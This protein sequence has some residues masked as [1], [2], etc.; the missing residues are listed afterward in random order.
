MSF[1]L[2]EPRFPEKLAE[3]WKTAKIV[4]N[5]NSKTVVMHVTDHLLCNNKECNRINI[6]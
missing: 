2:K 6:D 1:E 4:G 5:I 3:V